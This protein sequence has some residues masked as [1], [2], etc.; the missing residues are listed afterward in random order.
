MDDRVTDPGQHG[1]SDDLPIRGREPHRRHRQ[2]H[3][4]GAPNQKPEGAPN[5]KRAR[6]IAVDAEPH[7]RLQQGRGR[8]H[9]RHRQTEF[10][11]RDVETLLPG[12]EDRRQAKLIV[13]RQEMASAEQH[14][15]LGITVK[16]QKFEH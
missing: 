5:Q 2:G 6:A 15:D 7:R 9:H 12:Y 16:C 4:Q 11:E 10:G 13:L 3:R 1:Q 8:R 14:I